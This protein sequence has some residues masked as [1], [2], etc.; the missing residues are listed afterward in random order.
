MTLPPDPEWK[1]TDLEVI[2]RKMEEEHLRIQ[3][4]VMRSSPG[5]HREATLAYKRAFDDAYHAL[6]LAHEKEIELL[7]L[8]AESHPPSEF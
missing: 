5:E 1:R 8:C 4:D 7:S 2:L 6:R 3:R